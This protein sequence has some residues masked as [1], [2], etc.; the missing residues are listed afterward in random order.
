MPNMFKPFGMAR[1][2][3]PIH[4]SNTHQLSLGSQ[5]VLRLED[6]YGEDDVI[7]VGMSKKECVVVIR[8]ACRNIVNNAHRQAIIRKFNGQ[9]P[10]FVTYDS[11]GKP[12]ALHC[13]IWINML[14]GYYSV[15]NPS[16]DNI[17]A[18]PRALMNEVK[19]RLDD[20]WEYIGYDL[21]YKELKVQVNV[22]LK[23]K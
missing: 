11:S 2:K 13:N 12:K 4:L 1:T 21:A 8:K 22:Y 20:N 3:P 5:S 14:C 15:L 7:I 6:I 9:K 17:N 18:Q 16:V 10:F 19:G 23:N